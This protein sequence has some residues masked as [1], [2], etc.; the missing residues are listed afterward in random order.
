MRTLSRLAWAALLGL[1]CAAANA[2]E[3]HRK[4]GDLVNQNAQ[5]GKAALTSRGWSLAHSDELRGKTWQYWWHGKDDACALVTVV[6]ARFERIVATAE[7]DCMTK[8]GNPWRMSAK[9]KVTA[10]AAK[11]LG[12]DALMHRSHERDEQRHNDVR[13]VAE[14]ERGYRDGLQAVRLTRA[15][16]ADAYGDGHQAGS[17]RRAMQA[18]ATTPPATAQAAGPGGSLIGLRTAA[19]EVTMKA[20]GYERWSGFS[21]G[22]DSF[23]VWRQGPRQCLRTSARDDVVVDVSE[24]NETECP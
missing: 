15:P 18:Q 3:A 14:F 10:G 6:N 7:S 17:V 21:K 20:R 22:R 19:L 9:G 12:V 1:T 4:L 5:P 11:A 23:A 2:Q 16:G 13:A 8:G 24:V